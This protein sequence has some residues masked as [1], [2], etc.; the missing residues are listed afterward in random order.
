LFDWKP[1]YVQKINEGKPEI[2]ARRK[3]QLKV[4]NVESQERT[5]LSAKIARPA[6]RVLEGIRLLGFK[7]F[8]SFTCFKWPSYPW[9]LARVVGHAKKD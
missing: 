8:Q 5:C 4:Q 6:A 7:S 3:V 9:C 1:F 2:S